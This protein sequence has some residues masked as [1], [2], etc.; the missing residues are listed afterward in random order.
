MLT[1]TG[2][3]LSQAEVTQFFALVDKDQ[4]GML[5]ICEFMQM[6]YPPVNENVHLLT[7]L[8]EPSA[9]GTEPGGRAYA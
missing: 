9:A 7:R 4:D 8:R 1:Q 5:N 3:P 2:D 6:L